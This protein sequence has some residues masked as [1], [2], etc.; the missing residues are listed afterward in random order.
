MDTGFIGLGAMGSHMATHLLEADHH[1]TVYDVRRPAVESLADAGADGAS[2]PAAVAERADV[3]FLS[4]PGPDEVEAVVLG[5]DGLATGVAPGSVV[6]DLTTSLPETTDRIAAALADHDAEVLGAPVSG[7]ERGARA[8]TLSVMV[9]GDAR[10]LA[11]CEPV[12][13]A[14]A[15]R[16]F[17]VDEWV[18]AGHAV[19]LLNNYLW[20]VGFFAT[21][22]T[23]LLGERLGL[24]P[25]TVL[26]VVN[27]SSG[28]NTLTEEVFPEYVLPDSDLDYPMALFEKDLRLFANLGD[29]AGMPLVL[30]GLVRQLTGLARAGCGGDAD[31]VA[32]Y[33]LLEDLLG[34]SG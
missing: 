30:G 4:L 13:E 18:G 9:G 25:D 19:K 28:R 16:I 27:A 24:E 6:V 33:T 2:S 12:L 10:T 7:G 23:L 29:D 31:A 34:E 15:D 26:D 1:L 14:F 11:E 32:A 21:A 5:E 22:E 8:G 20:G 17:H 3:V